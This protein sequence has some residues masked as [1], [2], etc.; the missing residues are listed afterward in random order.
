MMINS[1][2]GRIIFPVREPFGSYLQSKFNDPVSAEP[3]VYQALYDSTRIFAIQQAEKNK[4]SLKGSY[5]SKY[6]SDI[7]SMQSI[8]RKDR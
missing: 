8:F 1:A 3:F 2:N 7:P 5:I 6:G 4:F